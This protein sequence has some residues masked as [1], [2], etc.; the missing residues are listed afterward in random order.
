MSLEEAIKE[1]TNAMRE[2]I[3][4]MKGTNTKTA[5]AVTEKTVVEKT[6]EKAATK[7]GLTAVTTG[8]EKITYDVMVKAFL[9]ALKKLGG[10]VHAKEKILKPLGLES[11]KEIEKEATR[12]PEVIAKIQEVLAA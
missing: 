4:A 6:V 11:L 12:F 7:T 9:A 8:D 10:A 1:N 2:L 5:P 3:A